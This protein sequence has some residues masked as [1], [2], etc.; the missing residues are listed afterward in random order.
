MTNLQR[1]KVYQAKDGYWYYA[2]VDATGNRTDGGE[3]VYSQGYAEKQDA[4]VAA[5]LEW[6]NM[7]ILGEGESGR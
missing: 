2:P 1:V 7:V 4:I 5:G 6:D 3:G